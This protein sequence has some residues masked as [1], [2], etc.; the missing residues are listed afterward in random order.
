MSQAFFIL[1]QLAFNSDFILTNW[2]K[3]FKFTNAA[4]D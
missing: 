2:D 3:N 1:F 4:I